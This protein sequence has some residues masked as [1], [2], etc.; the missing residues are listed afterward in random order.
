LVDKGNTVI[1]IEHNLDI[2]ASADYIID[3]GPG[4]GD[5]GGAIVATGT[6]EKVAKSSRSLTGKYLAEHLA[7]LSRYTLS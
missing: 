3:L 7:F 4:S 6:P 2:M 5:K 1:M